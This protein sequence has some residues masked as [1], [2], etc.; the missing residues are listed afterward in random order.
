M[1]SSLTIGLSR[2]GRLALFSV[3]FAAFM[4]EIN[5]VR[6]MAFAADKGFKHYLKT[7]YAD[8]TFKGLYHWNTF[9]A[10]LLIPYFLVMIVLAIYGIHRYTMCYHYVKF[11]KRHNPLPPRQFAE[12]PRVT[13]QLPIFNEQFVIDRLI[14][15][16]LL[17]G[18]P[19][20]GKVRARAIRAE[21]KMMLGRA[22]LS[23]N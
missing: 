4:L 12:F 20:M 13:V 10:A 2:S 9:D 18:I 6:V 19:A 11:R 3:S 15:A 21:N 1:K 8:R 17:I 5:P 16:V 23:N 14:E 22:A 7:H